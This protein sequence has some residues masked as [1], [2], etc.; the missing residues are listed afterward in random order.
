[1]TPTQLDDLR[2]ALRPELEVVSRDGEHLGV[3]SITQERAAREGLAADVRPEGQEAARSLHV[4]LVRGVAGSGKSLVLMLRAR[5]LREQHPDWNILLLTYN[6][7]LARDL[8]WRLR[9]VPQER[10]HVQTFHRLCHGLLAPHNLWHSPL[11]STSAANLFAR[12]M[13]DLGMEGQFTPAFLASEA[14]WIKDTMCVDPLHRRP[15]ED[16][17]LLADRTGRRTPLQHA[18]RRN[19]F[20]LIQ[21]YEEHLQRHH[22]WDWADIPLEVLR[23]LDDGLI[24]AGQYQAVLVDEA[25]DFAPSWFEVIKRMVDPATYVLFLAADAA[26]RIYRKFSWKD[27][28]FDVV[29]R[30]RVLRVNYRTTREIFTAAYEVVRS[31]PAL[32]RQLEREGEP[33]ADAE[34]PTEHMRSGEKPV[35]RSFSDIT[36]EAAWIAERIAFLRSKGG[37]ASDVAVLVPRTATV[38]RLATLLR[39][40]GVPVMALREDD[41]TYLRQDAVTIGTI[42]ASKGL[43]FR[44]VFACQLQSLFGAAGTAVAHP[45][46]ETS[47][48]WQRPAGIEDDGSDV[49]RLL[50]VG[51]TRARDRVYLSF[52]GNPA[53][54]AELLAPIR[55]LCQ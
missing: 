49:R 27:L 31:D 9:D 45:T 6:R 40:R 20:A 10:L 36:A 17:Y 47:A 18:Q 25:Q 50:Y 21:F 54:L 13:R 37:R 51:M 14:D 11:D 26:Q 32:L 5:Y 43:E 53:P 35:L 46:Y 23:A 39:E 4:R 28:G 7:A 29:G 41:D 2:T 52:Q 16:L 8:S 24:P 30:S 22:Q 19:A 42:R 48:T 1:V 3:V 44:T 38:T 33:L 12:F 15:N 34:A 55:P